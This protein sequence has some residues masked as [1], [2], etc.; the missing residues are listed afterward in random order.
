MANI[1]SAMK[2][3]KT[4]E[5]KRVRNKMIKTNLKSTIKKFD[6][7][8]A[9]DNKDDAQEAFYAASIKLDKAVSKGVMH[10]N[11][12]ARK[13]SILAKKVNTMNA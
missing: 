5:I 7:A 4:N 13:K 12:A 9:E 1:K 11:S 6:V 3:A 2:R 8:F 10:K